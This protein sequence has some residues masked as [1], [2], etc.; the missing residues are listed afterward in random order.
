M[1]SRYF[2][3]PIADDR[4]LSFS[5]WVVYFVKSKNAKV[6][7]NDEHDLESCSI[8]TTQDV[9]PLVEPVHFHQSDCF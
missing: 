8:G 4:D 9:V 6:D 2:E 5:L 1:A 3:I 7:I